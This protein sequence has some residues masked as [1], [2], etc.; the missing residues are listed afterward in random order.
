VS[1]PALCALLLAIVLPLVDAAAVTRGGAG[2]HASGTPPGA[3][4]DSGGLPL[5]LPVDLAAA[6][7]ILEA[8][9]RRTLDAELLRLVDAAQPAVRGR[10][11]LAVGRIGLPRGYPTLVERL[12]DPDAGVRALAAFGLG[13]LELDLE[14][15]T[16][17]ANRTRIVERLVPMLHDPEPIVVMRVLGA[18]GSHA[19]PS[20]TAAVLALLE[21]T[22]RDA[23]VLQAA[24]AA[25]WRLPAATPQPAAAHLQASDP[26]VRRAAAEAL[27]RLDDPDG[28]PALAAA[29]NDADAG[30]RV[31]AMR[32]LRRAPPAVLRRHLVAQL[33]DDDWRVQCA[34]LGW[35]TGLWR[36]D[37]EVDDGVFTAV[38][39]AS[40]AR[41]RHVQRCA[42]EAL[43]AAPGRYSVA[44]DRLLV[45]LRFGDATA[46]AAAT[47]AL[48]A[49]PDRL[50][51]AGAVLLEVYGLAAPPRESGAAEVPAALAEA[52]RAGAVVARALG[53]MGGDDTIAWLRLLAAHGPPATRAE[54]LRQLRRTDPDEA[55]AM[56]AAWLADGE[57]ALRAV[58]AE[59]VAELAAV[60]TLPDRLG[61]DGGSWSD[62]LWSAQR[63][64]GEAAAIEPRLVILEA[65]RSLDPELLEPRAAAL[66]PDPQRV[67]RLWALRTLPAPQRRTAELLAEA[68]G[69]LD[70]GRTAEDYRRLAQRAV[71]LQE[72]PPILEV[73]TARGSFAW[74]LRADWAPLAACTL[75]DVVAEGFY[76]GLLFHRVVPDFV[77]QTG[78]PSAVGYGGAPGSLRSEESPIPFTP[79]TVGLALAGRDTGGSQLFIV[80][81]PQHHLDGRY[82]VL[83]RV[84]E[85]PHV[86]ARIQPGDRLRVQVR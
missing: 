63:A 72:A 39:N 29:L 70:T 26:A 22:E 37:A 82:P 15:A 28:L 40:A 69:P 1:L 78:D 52:P 46:R 64:M 61:A 11:V 9:D 13:L 71:R 19:E 44:V 34:A 83:G 62:A 43:A 5:A 50:G 80:H 74:Q 12:R 48:A 68:I 47:E 53:G 49:N 25:W 32:G 76:D 7:V 6:A 36:D 24:L 31:A 79:G 3:Q 27:R 21:D 17:A 58:A 67:V 2:L 35:T 42:F 75:L 51:Q 23:G 59:V 16:A 66:L 30:V 4:L 54:A 38:L 81:S 10:A 73:E 77:V 18:L 56:A 14:P 57:P 8:E 45:A 41:D 86:V 55:A 33:G 60:G 20:S 65:L 85:Q 84:I